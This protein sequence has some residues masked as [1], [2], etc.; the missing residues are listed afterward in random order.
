MPGVSPKFND[1]QKKCL[2]NFIENML[3]FVIPFLVGIG[4]V[5]LFMITSL[6]YMFFRIGILI[7]F[8][9]VY[10]KWDFFK[11]I[12]NRVTWLIFNFIYLGYYIAE[13]IHTS[14]TLDSELI[15]HLRSLGIGSIIMLIIGCIGEVIL[16]LLDLLIWIYVQVK[17]CCSKS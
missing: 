7:K 4:N 14:D 2:V 17:K 9:S 10:S 3:L 12:F 11:E 6:F 15:S 8:R 13:K 5:D 16:V 1:E